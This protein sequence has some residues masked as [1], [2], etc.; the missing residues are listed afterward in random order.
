M[1]SCMPI[2]SSARARECA[3]APV[4][5]CAGALTAFRGGWLGNAAG[6]GEAVEREEP[7]VVQLEEPIGDVAHA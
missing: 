2:G 5:G 6:A 7:A 3:G 4:C 1:C